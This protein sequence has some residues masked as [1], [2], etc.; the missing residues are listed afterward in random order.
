VQEAEAIKRLVKSAIALFDFLS[1]ILACRQM[2]SEVGRASVAL[3]D[4][5]EVGLAVAA[6]VCLTV[7]TTVSGL[8]AFYFVFKAKEVVPGEKTKVYMR[9][10]ETM[11]RNRLG[12]FLVFLPALTNP[13]L[14]HHSE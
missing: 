4:G 5:G 7:S 2:I 11:S 12:Y 13:E 6:V 3:V 8:G 14:L 1:D 9:D 10:H